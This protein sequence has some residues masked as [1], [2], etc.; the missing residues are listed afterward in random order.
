MQSTGVMQR[1]ALL[2]GFNWKVILIRFIVNAVAL[3]ITVLLVPAVGFVDWQFGTVFLLALGLGILNAL[4]KPILQF[5]TLNFIF[6]TYGLIVVVINTVVLYLLAFFSQRFAVDR[7]FWAI[8]A[9]LLLGLLSSLLENLLGAT[10]PIMPEK[11]A[12][13]RKKLQKEV[14]TTA[15]IVETLV[16]PPTPLTPV[17][18]EPAPVTL[19]DVAP[20]TEVP[21]SE[22]SAPAASAAPITGELPATPADPVADAPTPVQTAGG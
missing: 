2:K 3:L 13:L 7:L 15:Q 5:L 22:G 12:D 6:V 18:A 4:I 19:P 9:A 16:E 14:P 11:H 20:A 21:P 1:F 10:L 8:V 17:E